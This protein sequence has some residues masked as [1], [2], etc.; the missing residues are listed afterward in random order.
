MLYDRAYGE[1]LIDLVD[2]ESVSKEIKQTVRDWE[3]ALVK[4][5]REAALRDAYIRK[6]GLSR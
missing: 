5:E 3:E 1:K 4:E 2:E 6:Y